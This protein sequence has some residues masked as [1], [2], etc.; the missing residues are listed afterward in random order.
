MRIFQ[1]LPILLFSSIWQLGNSQSNWYFGLE[2]SD[3]LDYQYHLQAGQF[4]DDLVNTKKSFGILA[5]R[6]L[7]DHLS[8]ETGIIS[9]SYHSTSIGQVLDI[10]KAGLTSSTFTALQIPIRLGTSIPLLRNRLFFTPTI[11]YS[12]SFNRDYK[13]YGEGSGGV[14]V[15][16]TDVVRSERRTIDRRLAQNFSL[17]ETG[18]GISLPAHP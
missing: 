11:G 10:G 12:L 5:G 18:L 8:L 6:Q 14:F 15:S 1:L 17:I 3:N 9:K 13:S 2:L 16:G 7:N 4:S